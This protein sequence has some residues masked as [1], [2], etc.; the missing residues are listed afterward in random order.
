MILDKDLECQLV[1]NKRRDN[2]KLIHDL[3]FPQG[4]IDALESNLWMLNEDFIHFRGYSNF[5]IRDLKIEGESIIR[6]NLSEDEKKT[7][8]E[9]NK[10][11]LGN[12]PDILLFPEE[13]KCIIIELKSDTA[14][15]TKYLNQAVNYA[16]LLRAFAKD[17]FVI[18]NFYLY[19]IAERFNFER[20]RIS[21]P[22]FRISQYLDYVFLPNSPVY[23]GTR[24]EGALY[25]EVLKYSTLLNRAKIR[26]SIFTE[27]LFDDEEDM[28]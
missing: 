6:D 1:K 12:K 10:D 5:K 14:D 26:N 21:N 13:H 28:G 17:E 2:E 15:P 9:Y 8:T 23:G 16:G 20:I 22:L 25:M 24:G 7:L 4:S 3:L 11:L 18:D 19:L 27:K